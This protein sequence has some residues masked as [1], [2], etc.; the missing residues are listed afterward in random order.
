VGI[1]APGLG[2]IQTAQ[3]RTFAALLQ[4]AA[5]QPDDARDPWW[6]LLAFFNSLRELGTTLSLIQSDIPD[7]LK[8]I[9]KRLG[10][11]VDEVR[12]LWEVFELTGRLRNDEVPKAIDDLSVPVGDGAYPIDV[13]LASNIVEVGIDID[14]LS[15][16]S[17]VGQPK[18]TSQYIQATGRVGRSW[19]E[20]PGLVVTIF[21]ASKPRDRSH[22]EKFRSYH[23]Q[24]YA[25]VEPTSVTPFSPPV[26]ERALHAVVTTFVRQTGPADLPAYPVPEQLLQ[27]AHELLSARVKRVDPVESGHLEDEL[28]QRRREWAAWQPIEC[29][30][31]PEHEGV[32][33]VLYGGSYADKEKAAMSWAVPTSMRNV[34]AECRARITTA[35]AIAD[36]AADEAELGTEAT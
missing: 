23:E 1:H 13:C 9:R 33:V 10:L 31:H 25:Q 6:T 22:F 2:S 3:V 32:P 5:L 19:K 28:A 26:L 36:A 18:S 15:L 8:V 35:Y 11:R 4:A 7:Y 30:P 12:R 29:G 20:K 34:D 21:G 27:K 14:R 24:L 16:M 17:V